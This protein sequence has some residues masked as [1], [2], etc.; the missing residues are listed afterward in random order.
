MYMQVRFAN[1]TFYVENCISLS[2]V[3]RCILHFVIYSLLTC[4]QSLETLK[5]PQPNIAFAN[6]TMSSKEKKTELHI[7]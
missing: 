2:R 7:D 3:M 6:S 4:S 1:N 5:I